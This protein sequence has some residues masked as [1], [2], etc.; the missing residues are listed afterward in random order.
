MISPR[1]EDARN[2]VKDRAWTQNYGNNYYINRSGGRHHDQ[3]LREPFSF[4]AN[5]LASCSQ[6]GTKK[7]GYQ[8]RRGRTV[9]PMRFDYAEN[10]SDKGI[11]VVRIGNYYGIIDGSGSWVLRPEYRSF[12]YFI[13]GY[14]FAR[15][16]TDKYDVLSDAGKVLL[17]SWVD[18]YKRIDST[19]FWGK[20]N[21][22]WGISTIEG[23][24]NIPP[25]FTI[26]TSFRSDEYIACE[27]NSCGVVDKKGTWLVK[28]FAESLESVS[29]G[30]SAAKSKGLFGYIDEKYE[31]AIDPVFEAAGSFSNEFAVV[32]QNGKFGMIDK[33]GNWFIKP[34]FDAMSSYNNRPL[35]EVSLDGNTGWAGKDGLVLYAAEVCGSYVL[36]NM[37]HYIVWPP[38]E[39]LKNICRQQNSN[40]ETGKF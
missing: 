19:T 17:K 10:F 16:E 26:L 27:N 32:K 35:V 4:S 8:N 25:Q 3:E 9:I 28:P 20:I 5:G 37:H 21:D 13:N 40:T 1:F 11:A 22:K 7:S 2:F 33:Q 30:L 12:I 14:D 29:N 15:K 34:E 36:K 23:K 6:Y 39:Q 31:W 24:W 38:P 18:D